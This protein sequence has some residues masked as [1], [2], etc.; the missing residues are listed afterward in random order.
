MTVSETIE[1]VVL[2]LEGTAEWR[3]RVQEDYP[4]DNR[5]ASAAALLE[6]LATE[7]TSSPDLV[8]RLSE[9]ESELISQSEKNRSYD[10]ST[11]V[12]ECNDYRRRIGFTESPSSG[13]E[14]LKR[15]IDIHEE[16]LNRA[17]KD[18]LDEFSLEDRSD[19]EISVR[20]RASGH[21]YRFMIN[22][23]GLPEPTILPNP[24][25]IVVAESLKVA[26]RRAA[27]EH[28]E[29]PPPSTFRF[30]T[31]P[32]IASNRAGSPAPRTPAPAR[33]VAIGRHLLIHVPHSQ[34]E[35]TALTPCGGPRN[36][37]I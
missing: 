36:R 21:V 1:L 10:L 14:Y 33:F 30:D 26:A 28:I 32:T 6:R 37:E 22:G 2:D 7:I 18:W 4:N 35:R 25:T 5:N 29:S 15:L 23:A 19:R 12:E 24:E 17:K 34:N 16:A 20:H 11:V 31:A 13:K 27:L 9:I 3:R 8:A